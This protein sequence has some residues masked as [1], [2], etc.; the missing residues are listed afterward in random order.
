[1]QL[2]HL[3][4]E[5]KM[6]FEQRTPKR[7]FTSLCLIAAFACASATS[8]AQASEQ[9]QSAIAFEQAGQIDEAEKAWQTIAA[10]DPKSAE[11][12]AHLGLLE[13][14]Q[15]H[16][17]EAIQSYRKALAINPQFPNLRVNLG[18]S[19]FKAGELKETIQTYEPMLKEMPQASPQRMRI[20]TLTGLAQYGLGNYA[21]AVPYLKEAVADE[22]TNLEFRLMHAHSCLWTKQFPCV[23]DEY[24]EILTLSPD[25][26]EAHM[27]A[28]EAYDG[29]RFEAKAIEEF[30]A[31]IKKDPTLPNVHF[32]YGYMQW[33]LLNLDLA[34]AQ[35]EAELV[36]NPDHALALTYLGDTKVRQNQPE[37]A[38]PLLEHAIK[39]TPT[40]ALAH[41]DLGT[42]Y[43]GLSRKDEALK[44][45]QTAVSLSPNDQ[46]VHW[47]LG[48]FYQSIGRSAEAKIELAKAQSLQKAADESVLDKIRQAKP[49]TEE[50]DLGK[51][52][53]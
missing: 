11:A 10:Q 48:R 21:A 49:R 40:I 17:K 22:P 32:G 15:E 2:V 6:R 23:L 53:K 24:K 13:A 41:L 36:N 9:R 4:L 50:P 42:V 27:L 39:I 16:Y 29:E 20:V 38:L 44:E 46:K 18:L 3:K 28:G 33:R 31:A 30:E 19:Y 52:P 43:Q 1:M 35:F 51:A 8:S 37:A 34:A 26:A 14:R 47:T 45:Y 5:M 7:T 12:Y 25:S